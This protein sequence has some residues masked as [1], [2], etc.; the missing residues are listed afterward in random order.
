MKKIFL[1]V[2]TQLGSKDVGGWYPER[3]K[4]ALAVTSD[5][6]SGF[7]TW[8]ENQAEQLVDELLTFDRVIGYNLLGFD[9]QVLEAY[10]PAI[11]SRLKPR[12]IDMMDCIYQRLGFRLKLDDLA[13]HTLKK[14]KTGDGLQSLRWWAEG[15][16]DLIESYCQEDVKITQ[17][18]YEFGKA[19]GVI[20]YS[21][22]WK[23]APL[24]CPW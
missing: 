2:E 16:I 13:L 11:T 7:R 15:K 17:A 6:A 9:F 4:M 14:Q 10:S 1:D 21:R 19:K 22:N 20:Y 24:Q 3:M 23:P 8:F 12:T 18:I 5:E